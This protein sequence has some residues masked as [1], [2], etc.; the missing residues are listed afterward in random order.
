MRLPIANIGD[1]IVTYIDQELMP[2]ASPT[3]KWVT[4]FVGVAFARQAESL[5]KQHIDMCKTTGLADDETIDIEAVRDLALEA[6]GKS[7]PV[8]VGGVILNKEDV[9]IIYN[10]AKKYS[11]E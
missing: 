9:P 7:G 4:T 3:Q 5:F 1:V 8:N 11:R 10:I 2:K 6:F